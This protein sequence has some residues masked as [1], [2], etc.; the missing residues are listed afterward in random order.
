MFGRLACHTF[1]T[2]TWHA[3][4][5]TCARHTALAHSCNNRSASNGFWILHLRLRLAPPTPDNDIISVLICAADPQTCAADPR[6][7]IIGLSR[8]C[9]A[10]PQTCAADPRVS[11][12]LRL[13]PR[14]LRP[15]L[16]TPET[17]A[18]WR[19]LARARDLFRLG[20]VSPVRS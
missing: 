6:V 3:H 7:S 14:T 16:P 11:I 10:D 17:R 13:A 9:T 20:V 12:V 2:I 15:L 19:L 8:T 4:T 18:K 1:N 5:H